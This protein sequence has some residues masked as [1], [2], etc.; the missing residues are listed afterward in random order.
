MQPWYYT[1][2]FYDGFPGPAVAAVGGAA[3]L[4]ERIFFEKMIII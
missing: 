2:P 4:A 3:F 1:Y